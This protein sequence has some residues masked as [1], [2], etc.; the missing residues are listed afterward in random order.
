MTLDFSKPGKFIINMKKYLNEMMGDLPDDMNG[1]GTSP[2]AEHLFKTRD[3]AHKLP[4]EQID[5]I[6][7]VTAQLLFVCKRGCPD[8]QTAVSFQCTR[9]KCPD[10]DGYKKLARV[11][12][13][14]PEQSE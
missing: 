3:N 5:M 1:E 8:I 9:V 6:H 7:R 10:Q 13:T 4:M 14:F 12:S 11:I 2:A